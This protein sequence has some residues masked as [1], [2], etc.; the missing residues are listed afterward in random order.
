M[1]LYTALCIMRT[2]YKDIIP[3]TMKDRYLLVFAMQKL[4][5]IKIKSKAII[6]IVIVISP[7]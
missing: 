7:T 1:E 6:D 5:K 4:K 3:K 2:Q